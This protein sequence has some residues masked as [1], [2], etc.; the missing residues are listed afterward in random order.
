MRVAFLIDLVDSFGERE[1]AL[2]FAAGLSPADERAFVVPREIAGHLAEGGP[3]HAYRDPAEVPALLAGLAPEVLVCVE[4]YNLPPALQAH[5]AA[6]PWRLATT[7]G[8]ALGVEINSN[9]FGEPA[10]RRTLEIPERLVRLPSCPVHDPG[11][12]SERALHWAMWPGI[13]RG[14]RDAARRELGVKAER[15]AMMA[16]SPWALGHAHGRREHHERLFAR[17]VE[18]LRR[19]GPTSELIVVSP[20]PPR[21]VRS[22]PVTVRFV[23]LLPAPSYQR[24][25]LGCDLFVS[26][27][28]LQMSAA[29]AFA[30]GVPTLIVVNSRPELGAPYDVFPLA[31]RFP[32]NQYRAA[33]A[34]VELGDAEAI[35]GRVAEAMAGGVVSATASAYRAALGGLPTPAEIVRRLA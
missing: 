5:V 4:Y 17:L 10:P 28:L 11:P 12:D 33:V 24:L 22:G 14:E 31:V 30:A 34:P 18:A 16:L 15:V 27:N 8:T 19:A 6:G 26:D 25:L 9:P 13:A 3:V 20:M 21:E 2:R 29:K 23:G 35:A 7:D 1:L 32:E